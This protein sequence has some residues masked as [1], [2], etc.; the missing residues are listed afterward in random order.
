MTQTCAAPAAICTTRPFALLDDEEVELEE[1]E[2]LLEELLV[3]LEELETELAL[4]DELLALLVELL[5]ALEALVEALSAPE[6]PPPLQ[7]AISIPN[8][9][10]NDARTTKLRIIHSLI[11]Y[12]V[13]YTTS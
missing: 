6:E 13:S 11:T 12:I 4:L 2:L 3:L 5:L 7:A 1:L 8:R 9:H 10:T